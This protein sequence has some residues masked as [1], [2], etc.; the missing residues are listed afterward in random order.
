MKNKE[1][2]NLENFKYTKEFFSP[3]FL[4]QL[5]IITQILNE[6]KDRFNKEV[7][8][9]DLGAQEIEKIGHKYVYEIMQYLD[10]QKI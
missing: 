10:K 5:L 3:K 2:V 9:K 4:Q 1:K 7:E 6:F 8:G